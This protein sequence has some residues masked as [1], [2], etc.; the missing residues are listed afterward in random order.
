MKNIDLNKYP[1]IKEHFKK[2]ITMW[3]DISTGKLKVKKFSVA[4]LS[5]L[6]KKQRINIT[7]PWCG[8][9][10]STDK[11]ELTN[12]GKNCKYG[13]LLTDQGNAYKKGK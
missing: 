1:K 13:A 12:M 3:K 4:H 10:L 2:V 8:E 9:I 6:L 7:C 5:L 11:N